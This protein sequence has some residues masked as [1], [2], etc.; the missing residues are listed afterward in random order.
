MLDFSHWQPD[1][2]MVQGSWNIPVPAHQ[3]LL[4]PDMF[5]IPL[6][7]FDSDNYR[8]GYGGGY[9]DRTLAEQTHNVTTIGVGIEQGRFETIFP[10][11]HDI[12]MNM[13]VTEAG[14]QKT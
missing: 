9:Y 2:P 10:Q 3:H 5:L 13:I 7:G 6:L 1:M 12:A 4:A 14:I 11:P 8:L